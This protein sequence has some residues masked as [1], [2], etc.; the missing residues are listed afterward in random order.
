MQ[1][2]TGKG[3][4]HFRSASAKDIARDR[5]LDRSLEDPPPLPLWLAAEERRTSRVDANV[6]CSSHDDDPDVCLTPSDVV[7]VHPS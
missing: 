7:C 2:H 1:I 4:P 3:D 6:C 5:E